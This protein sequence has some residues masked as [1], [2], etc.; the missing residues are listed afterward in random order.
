MMKRRIKLA[1]LSIRAKLFLAISVIFLWLVMALV[2]QL[3][4]FVSYIKQYNEMTNTITLTN[5]IHGQL[6]ENLDEEIRNIVY[7]KVHFDDGKQYKLLN[8]MERHLKEVETK[9]EENR[10]TKEITSVYT[11]LQTTREYIDQ[12]G[13]QMKHDA[14]V[15]EKYI[16][17][18]YIGI[19]SQLI[20]EDVQTLIQKTLIESEK[21][22]KEIHQ[23]LTNDI[24]LSIIIV[25]MVMIS[26]IIFVLY[27]SRTIVKP[28]H[29]L[30]DYS[31]QIAKGNLTIDMELITYRNEAGR[32]YESFKKMAFHLKDMIYSVLNR[33]KEIVFISTT[34]YQ[35]AED[36]IKIGE[37]VGTIQQSLSTYL[38]EHGTLVKEALD[39]KDKLDHALYQ[40]L[41]ADSIDGEKILPTIH[42]YMEKLD[43]S[44]IDIKEHLQKNSSLI[45]KLSALNEE[46]LTTVEEIADASEKQLDQVKQLKHYIKKF[47]I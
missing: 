29:L 47:K 5:S 16:T 34:I 20:S 40:Y 25:L 18:E 44:M 23:K 17:Q 4:I 33:S 11:I 28:I 7:G 42:G 24:K 37:E 46:Q 8:Q 38:N 3:F 15:E 2:M 6:R 9:D 35:S 12:L 26:A 41:K 45:E 32:L 14:P 31:T 1:D 22:E 21:M 36:N 39:W 43:V 19:A 13:E 10:F 27:I 30:I